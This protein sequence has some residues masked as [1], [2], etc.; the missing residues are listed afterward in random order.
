MLVGDFNAQL[1]FLQL[2]RA[3][4]VLMI[5]R[6]SNKSSFNWIF[7]ILA[8]NEMYHTHLDKFEFQPDLT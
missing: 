7:F 1:A 8:G 3:A 6:S 4:V 2:K 5:V